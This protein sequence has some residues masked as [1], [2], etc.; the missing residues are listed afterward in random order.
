[1]NKTW[2]GLLFIIAGGILASMSV[3]QVYNVTL[4][5]L[6]EH[7]WVSLPPQ[8]NKDELKKMF[9]RKPVILMYAG[10]L[11]II[12]LFILWNRNS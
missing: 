6:V 1:M 9:G 2:I 8:A 10:V 12:G 3:D 7:E 4:G 11:I 5:W